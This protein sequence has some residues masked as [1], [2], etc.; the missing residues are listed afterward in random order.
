[1]DCWLNEHGSSARHAAVVLGSTYVPKGQGDVQD[2]IP[3]KDGRRD[4]WFHFPRAV[5]QSDLCMLLVPEEEAYGWFMCRRRQGNEVL[6]QAKVHG[7]APF[8]SPQESRA[9]AV[10][11]GMACGDALGHTLEFSPYRPCGAASTD[12]TITGAPSRRLNVQVSE[13]EIQQLVDGA[14]GSI[15]SFATASG[16]ATC[17]DGDQGVPSAPLL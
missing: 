12:I 13:P 3:R 11:L 8:E 1:M 4:D 5:P 2:G 17:L 7:E 9:V 15:A 16:G 10:V 14:N 6:R